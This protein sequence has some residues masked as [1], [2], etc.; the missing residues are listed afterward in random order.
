MTTGTRLSVVEQ[1]AESAD[2]T[3]VEEVE[4]MMTSHYS[5]EVRRLEVVAVRQTSKYEAQYLAEANELRSRASRAQMGNHQNMMGQHYKTITEHDQVI[6]KLKA[7]LTVAQSELQN[8]AA[9]EAANRQLNGELNLARA[10]AASVEAKV[11][12][13]CE[14]AVW[15]RG[16]TPP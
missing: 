16:R 8:L 15:A 3:R 12:E 11:H 2:C 10:Q 9:A 13:R 1:L 5:N 7:E 6:N 14:N 4:A